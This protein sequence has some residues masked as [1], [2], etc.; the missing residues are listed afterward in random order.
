MPIGR[1][2]NIPPPLPRSDWNAKDGSEPWWI[3]QSKCLGY[4]SKKTRKIKLVN[5][6]TGDQHVL[7]VLHYLW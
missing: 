2:L 3:D 5:T 1:F 7:E 4:L 6:L